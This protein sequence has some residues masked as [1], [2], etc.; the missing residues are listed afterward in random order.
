MIFES[1]SKSPLDYRNL[2]SKQSFKEILPFSEG[3][4][5]E[6]TMKITPLYQIKKDI[7]GKSEFLLKM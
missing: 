4:S 6:K 5:M 7:Y 3:Q 2:N 1:T